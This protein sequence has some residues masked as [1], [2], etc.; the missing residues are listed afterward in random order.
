MRLST[1]IRC[2]RPRLPVT[3][4]SGFIGNGNTTLLNR[5]LNNREEVYIAVITK[6]VSDVDIYGE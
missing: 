1:G 2:Q 6:D 4:F 5:A 3:A